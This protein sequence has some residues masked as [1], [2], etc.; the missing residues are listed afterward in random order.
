MNECAVMQKEVEFLQSR[1]EFGNISHHKI[2]CISSVVNIASAGCTHF[3]FLAFHSLQ[4]SF[5]A[6]AKSSDQ[7]TAMPM[8]KTIDLKDQD[9][10]T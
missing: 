8:V 5:L 7:A 1:N 4:T 10:A 2:R 9:T 6:Q 3:K